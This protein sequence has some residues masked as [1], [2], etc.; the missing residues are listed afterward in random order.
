MLPLPLLSLNGAV[1]GT[2]IWRLIKY[3]DFVCSFII[4][5]TIVTLCAI[6]PNLMALAETKNW[7]IK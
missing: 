3:N 7:V 2:V 5:F 1:K 4:G 6:K